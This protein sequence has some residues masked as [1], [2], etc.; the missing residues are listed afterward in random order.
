[1][2]G[3]LRP[4]ARPGRL[5]RAARGVD[6]GLA[7]RDIFHF[8]RRGAMKEGIQEFLPLR[9]LSLTTTPRGAWLLFKIALGLATDWLAP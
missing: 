9:S 4:F 7:V 2:G 5:T 1:M 8:W 6:V 3:G